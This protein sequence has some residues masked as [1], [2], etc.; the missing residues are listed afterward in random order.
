MGFPFYSY[1][2][3]FDDIETTSIVLPIDSTNVSKNG[4]VPYTLIAID[5]RNRQAVT[6]GTVSVI[7]YTTPSVTNI[8]ST[9]TNSD[10]TQ[11]DEGTSGQFN[12]TYKIHPIK[13]NNVNKNSFTIT[14]Q[15]K[16]DSSSTSSWTNIGSW[17]QTN[18]Y[19]A[20]VTTFV[21]SRFLEDNAYSIH[22]GKSVFL[23]L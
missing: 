8:S 17:T 19:N 7:E 6:T 10:H 12:F 23:C 14:L 15:M 9:R 3:I 16:D 22:N 20:T 21:D 2:L 13:V 1:K 18:G 4:S 5:S 11:F